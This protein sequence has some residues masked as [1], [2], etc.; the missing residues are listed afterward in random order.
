[1][2]NKYDTLKVFQGF[3]SNK[4][5]YIQF[6]LLCLYFLKIEKIHMKAIFTHLTFLN[7]IAAKNI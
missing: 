7:H 2:D 1:M 6:E 3:Q 4:F 5:E